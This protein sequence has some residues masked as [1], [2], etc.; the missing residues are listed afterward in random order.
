MRYKVANAD[1]CI[2]HFQLIQKSTED[3]FKKLMKNKSVLNNAIK[4]NNQRNSL[5]SF[6]GSF[7]WVLAFGPCVSERPPMLFCERYWMLVKAL[8]E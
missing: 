4:L 3:E 1:K 6:V 7:H 5:R 8:E 2:Q